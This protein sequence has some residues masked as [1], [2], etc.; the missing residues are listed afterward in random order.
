MKL[1][2]AM[3]CT[4][5]LISACGS[6]PPR[7]DVTGRVTTSD[8]S[9]PLNE[10]LSAEVGTALFVDGQISVRTIP[11][12][13]MS[14]S[15]SSTMPG[16]YKVPFAFEIEKTELIAQYQRGDDEFFCANPSKSSA[17]FP[18]LGIVVAEGDCIGV[19]R[20]IETGA[21]RW[22]VDNSNY[23]NGMTTVWSRSVKEGDGI[24]FTEFELPANEQV[25][26]QR[27]VFD[28]AYSGLLHFTLRGGARNGTEFKFDYPSKNGDKTYG[29]LGYIFEV[30]EVT[31]TSIRY[32]WLSIPSR[33][34][35]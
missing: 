4:V 32:K 27:F 23:N 31:N 20:S 30:I 21:L 10:V 35:G 15:I 7:Q 14:G 16:A 2:L 33:A 19:M 28:G 9:A 5:F 3:L 34:K 1:I 11:A 13:R 25:T 8:W 22:A 26:A 29:A 12:L 17:S 24:A 18:G 6:A